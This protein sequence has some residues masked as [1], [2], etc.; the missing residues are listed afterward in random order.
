MI[1][2]VSLGPN[3]SHTRRV[4]KDDVLSS[5]KNIEQCLYSLDVEMSIKNDIREKVTENLNWTLKK[6]TQIS[7]EERNFTKKLIATNK[8]LKNN[9]NIMF[10]KAD[11]G[12][13][14]VCLNKSDYT[15]KMLELLSDQN[16]YTNV[17]RNPLSKLRL[18]TKKILNNLNNNEFLS[19]RYH[20]NQLTLT[21][22]TLAKGYGL[23]KIH[24]ENAPL[25]PIISLVNSPTHLLAKIIYN[26]LKESIKLP[27]SHIN[28]S[29]EL[30]DKLKNF[31]LH[32][33]HILLSLDVKSLFTNIPVELVCDSIDKRVPSIMNKCLIPIDEIKTVSISYMTTLTL[34]SITMFTNKYTVHRWVPQPLRSLLILLWMIWKKR[35][36]KP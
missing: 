35:V 20:K 28:N 9:P 4:S 21:N 16:T 11:K 25:R 7:T 26:E 27:E 5:I 33:E 1:D 32:D 34:L 8:F 29:F 18:D 13:V 36:Y 23:P 22:T 2:I 24:K 30:K 3:F 12:N 10:T 19:H 6:Q 17:N 15:S 14:T 31:K